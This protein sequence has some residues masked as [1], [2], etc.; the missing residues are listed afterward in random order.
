MKLL[1][2]F[3]PRQ[4]QKEV[5]DIMSEHNKLRIIA[6]TSAGKSFMIF[7]DI[8]NKMQT[9]EDSLFV[10]VSSRIL[11]LQQLSSEYSKLIGNTHI[12]HMHSGDS[13][14][15][16]ITDYLEFAYWCEKVK[17]PKVVFVTYHSLKKIVKSEVEID[18][19]Y[20]DECHNGAKKHF[21]EYVKGAEVISKSLYS[22]T[23]TPRYHEDPKKNGNNNVEVYGSEVYNINA[24]ELIKNGSIL[25]P[26]ISPLRIPDVRERKKDVHERDYYTLMDCLL[27][28][29]NTDRVLITCPS[30]RS[31]MDL[32]CLT[33]F[34][35]DL[36]NNGYD[37]FHITSKYG[38]FH[39]KTKLKRTEFLKRIEDY[40]KEDK[41]FVILHYSILT[42][43]WSNNS[44]QSSI[45]MRPQSMGATVQ[46]VG[47]TLRLGHTDIERINNGELIPGDYDNYE[48]PYGNV[49]VPVYENTG[50]NIQEQVEYVIDEVF[51]R[52]NYVFD[53]ITS[54]KEKEKEVA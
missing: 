25:P 2:D 7:L 26:K 35:Q 34:V 39:N 16:K 51:E 12:V 11:L 44:I 5:V 10:I 41:K 23:A 40:G 17:G 24:V 52:G 31:L 27:N 47:R 20:L 19:I 22:F 37:L 33:D 28:E 13:N 54:P 15:R 21:F 45:F 3:Q 38:A 49:I 53:V 9:Q 14:N 1:T 18:A 36:N 8:F 42:E 29:D 4:S 30:T 43:G 50:S 48:K 46:N 32:L 6:P